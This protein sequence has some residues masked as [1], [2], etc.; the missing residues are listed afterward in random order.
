MIADEG[1]QKQASELVPDRLVETNDARR[2]HLLD[3]VQ[4]SA[5]LE[6]ES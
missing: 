3:A 6:D 2:A 5:V 4:A 1:A